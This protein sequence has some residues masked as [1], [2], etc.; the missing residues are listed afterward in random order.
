MEIQFVS[1]DGGNDP[2]LNIKVV[3][4]NP[5]PPKLYNL[6]GSWYLDVSRAFF[7]ELHQENVVA[8]CIQLQK[9]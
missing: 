5:T 8:L 7:F 3:G 1:W 6:E 9:G 4:S 2:P